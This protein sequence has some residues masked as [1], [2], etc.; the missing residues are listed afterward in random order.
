M[1]VCL[2]YLALY[3]N[4]GVFIMLQALA[5]TGFAVSMRVPPFWVKGFI[6]PP[7]TAP[8]LFGCAHAVGY[9]PGKK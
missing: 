5:L 1:L 6:H 7:R 8:G 3:D 2:T 9:V 4:Q